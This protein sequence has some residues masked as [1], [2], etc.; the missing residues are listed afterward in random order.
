[1]KLGRVQ[2]FPGGGLRHRV[3][4]LG[5]EGGGAKAGGLRAWRADGP[6]T[7]MGNWRAARLWRRGRPCGVSVLG[8]QAS[9][10]A[11]SS[12]DGNRDL[13]ARLVSS[14]GK[15]GPGLLYSFSA[16]L[17]GSCETARRRTQRQFVS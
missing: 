17:R 6:F 15:T 12:Q 16:L 14:L 10:M 5:T 3:G 8:S 4:D 7:E 1:M 9:F 2:R 13:L 11:F